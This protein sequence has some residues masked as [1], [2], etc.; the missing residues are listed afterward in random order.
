MKKLTGADIDVWEGM[1]LFLQD[2]IFYVFAVL[3]ALGIVFII[4]L[5]VNVTVE[6]LTAF[7][8][9]WK[10]SQEWCQKVENGFEKNQIEINELKDFRRSDKNERERLDNNMNVIYREL[11]EVRDFIG[12]DA[13]KA[14]ADAEKAIEESVQ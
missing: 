6:K 14:Q 11:K 12:I 7:Y 8:V 1:L 2:S 5:L 3:F 9:T 4:Y 10:K 13:Q